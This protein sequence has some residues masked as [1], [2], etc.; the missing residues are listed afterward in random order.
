ME[1]VAGHAVPHSGRKLRVG[2]HLANDVHA[3]GLPVLHPAAVTPPGREPP[4]DR[5]CPVATACTLKPP[6]LHLHVPIAHVK[7]LA[8]P[9]E[10]LQSQ[11]LDGSM[12]HDAMALRISTCVQVSR[13]WAHM[14]EV[15]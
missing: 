6:F 13:L 1:H 4:G 8:C 10:L 15:A 9:H 11:L 3:A 5:R 12:L 14:Q 2:A 7:W